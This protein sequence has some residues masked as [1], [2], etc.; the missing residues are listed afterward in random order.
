MKLS[1]LPIHTKLTGDRPKIYTQGVL[2][3]GPFILYYFED[4]KI[5]WRE[6]PGGLQSMGSQRVGHD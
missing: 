4:W 5:P 1:Y 6:K 2:S 3:L